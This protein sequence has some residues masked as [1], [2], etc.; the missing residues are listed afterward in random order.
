[1]PHPLSLNPETATLERGERLF[2]WQSQA[3]H[4]LWDDLA[5]IPASQIDFALHYTLTTLCNWLRIESAF[6]VGTSPDIPGSRQGGHSLCL[7]AINPNESKFLQDCFLTSCIKTDP[8]WATVTADRAS[9][10]IHHLRSLPGNSQTVQQ[11]PY[12]Q[13]WQKS[14]ELYDR[15][16]V[17]FQ[18]D[19]RAT[20]VFHFDIRSTRRTFTCQEIEW[21]AYALRG[22][23]WFHRELLLSHGL[24]NGLT[25]LTPSERRLL[26]GLLTDKR[27]KEIADFYQLTPATVHQYAKIIYQKLKVN[28]RTGLSA[29][30]LN[31]SSRL[32]S[33]TP[34]VNHSVTQ[35]TATLPS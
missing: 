32:L 2:L 16:C 29:L 35:P 24:L 8:F 7:Q 14:I 33:T 10:H 31:R 20:S 30:W 19:D 34:P 21:I 13:I 25:R 1:M 15:V 9:F 26:Q 22:I 5:D 3:A 4:T 18:V 23:K 12:Y 11:S 17:C 27:E 6:W 28:G